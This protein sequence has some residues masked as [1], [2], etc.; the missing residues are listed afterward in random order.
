MGRDELLLDLTLPHKRGDSISLVERQV[1]LLRERALDYRHQLGRLSENARD[2]EQLF[3][4]I[5]ALMLSL[6][7]SRDLEH[8]IETLNDS[9]S[10]EF[11]IEFQSL[12]LFSGK[13]MSLPVRIEHTDVAIMVLGSLITS[14]KVVCGQITPSEMDFL[15]QEHSEK[16]NSV[17][18]VPLTYTL[19]DPPQ[20]GIL[21]LGSSDK[22][23][24][25]ASM[26]T[27]F[28]HYLGD[29]LSRLLARYMHP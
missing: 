5:R 17:A 15:F 12:I 13:P 21:A 28:V 29:V 25:K 26:G 3:E 4:K 7:E 20:L 24:F 27:V 1:A 8:L 22:N 2:N 6:L 19:I 16:I 9:L 10:H 18:I 23:H 11:G 14:G